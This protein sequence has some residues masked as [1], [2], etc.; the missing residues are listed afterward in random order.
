MTYI[1]GAI[2][3]VKEADKEAY[4]AMAA[5]M[6][7]LFKKHGALHVFESWGVD[8]A[9]GIKASFPKVVSLEA[10]EGVVFSFI[11]WPS[12]EARETGMKALM[13]DQALM[14]MDTN[15]PFDMTRMIHGG[16]EAIVEL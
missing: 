5:S 3:P 7:A 2:I 15:R 11:V 10:G 1:N 16:V 13:S 8:L 12:K 9:D 4:R 6:G 14:D